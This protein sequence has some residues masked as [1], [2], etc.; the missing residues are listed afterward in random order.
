[1][2]VI[3]RT[4]R[5]SLEAQMD[6]ACSCD[7]FASPEARPT[8]TNHEKWSGRFTAG[9]HDPALAGPGSV[10]FEDLEAKRCQ[11]MRVKARASFKIIHDDPDV[12]E[13]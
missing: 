1:M 5:R 7:S 12:I 9:D 3:D 6:R 11:H 2:E 13:H 4:L 8:C 10:L